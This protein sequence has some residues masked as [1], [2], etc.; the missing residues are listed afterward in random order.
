[1]MKLGSVQISGLGNLVT[2]GIPTI[3]YVV[4]SMKFFPGPA[5]ERAK[6]VKISIPAMTS[7]SAGDHDNLHF[8]E[9]GICFKTTALYLESNITRK[10]N[11]GTQ[12]TVLLQT[13]KLLKQYDIQP[14]PVLNDQLES[15]QFEIPKCESILP[16][17]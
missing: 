10:T 17:E 14:P 12:S 5:S 9:K 11:A 2:H 4:M 6:L 16:N 15:A 7:R 13:W 3:D 1:M 8:A